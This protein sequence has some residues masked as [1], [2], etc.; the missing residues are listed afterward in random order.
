MGKINWG[1]AAVLLGLIAL[2]VA[3]PLLALP[4]GVGLGYL[5]WKS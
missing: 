2:A 1:G 4:I 5:Y 3:V